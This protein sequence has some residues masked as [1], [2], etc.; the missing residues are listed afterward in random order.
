MHSIIGISYDFQVLTIC[1]RYNSEIYRDRQVNNLD[2]NQAPLILGNN[3]SRRT[4]E[5]KFLK[6]TFKELGLGYRSSI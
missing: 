3:S 2:K 5:L 1:S 6:L 4:Q